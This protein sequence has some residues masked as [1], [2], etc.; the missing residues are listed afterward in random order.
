VRAAAARLQAARLKTANAQKLMQTKVVSPD[1]GA[2]QEAAAEEADAGLAAAKVEAERAEWTLAQTQIRA[3]IDGRVSRAHA[4]AGNLVV[5]DRT[6][7]LTIV[8]T[9]RLHV[10]FEVDEATLLRLRRG[11]LSEPGRLDV[12]VAFAGEEGYPHAATLDLIAPEVDP[13]T[14]TVRFRAT[15]ANPAGLLAPGM[16]ARVRLTPPPK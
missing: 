12:A 5:A 4:T 15:L 6:P 2:L 3:P 7:V 10:S 9:G 14:G 8:A 1:E 11:G 13:G 16:F